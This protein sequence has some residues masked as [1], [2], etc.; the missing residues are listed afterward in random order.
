MIVLNQISQKISRF[1]G[2]CKICTF[3]YFIN[4]SI[5][6]FVG[7]GVSLTRISQFLRSSLIFTI[8]FYY[9]ANN[10]T[11]FLLIV[12]SIVNIDFHL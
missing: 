8:H 6:Y 10:T 2:L 3:I 11:T 9:Y 7:L 4:I 5:Q 12:T 1:V